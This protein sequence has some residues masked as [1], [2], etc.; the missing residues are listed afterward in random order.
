MKRLFPTNLFSRDLKRI[1]KRGYRLVKLDL[2]LSVLLNEET[3]PASVR[4]HKL[5]GE[6]VGVWECHIEPDWLLIY[7]I[8]TEGIVL[9]RTGTHAD[10]FD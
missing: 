6:W 4:Q 3:L 7:E 10:L 2:I 5:T 1:S 9:H 8:K